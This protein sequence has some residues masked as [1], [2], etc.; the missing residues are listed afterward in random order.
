MLHNNTRHYDLCQ[1]YLGKKVEPIK[2]SCVKQR[3]IMSE[4]DFLIEE[5]YRDC[6]EPTKGHGHKS[7]ADELALTLKICS[8]YNQC[9]KGI[10][11]EKRIRFT[12]LVLDRSFNLL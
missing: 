5:L 10:F 2:I 9:I 3:I 7:N 4:I 6:P 1:L 12:Q 8:Q 11:D